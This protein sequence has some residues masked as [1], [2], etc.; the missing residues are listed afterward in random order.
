MLA[1]SHAAMMHMYRSAC[2]LPV[3]ND[4]RRSIATQAGRGMSVATLDN[5]AMG[6]CV[7]GSRELRGGMDHGQIPGQADGQLNLYLECFS[8]ADSR[9]SLESCVIAR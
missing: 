6:A 3:A 2:G 8:S 5:V 4:M 7:I 9:S 1:A